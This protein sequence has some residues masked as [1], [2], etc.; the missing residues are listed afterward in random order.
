MLFAAGSGVAQ[1][2]CLTLKVLSG[3][4]VFPERR[5]VRIDP[6]ESKQSE[7]LNFSRSQAKKGEIS[8][9]IRWGLARGVCSAA[10]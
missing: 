9:A 6:G 5:F 4:T 10:A 7:Q 2:P 3:P 1:P 8:A